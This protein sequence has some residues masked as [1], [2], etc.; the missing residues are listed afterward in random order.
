MLP[1]KSVDNYEIM[2]VLVE[3]Q[4]AWVVGVEVGGGDKI[5]H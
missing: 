5:S 2:A 1:A 4:N 3:E